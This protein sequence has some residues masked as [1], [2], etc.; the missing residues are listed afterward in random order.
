MCHLY[1]RADNLSRSKQFHNSNSKAKND[2]VRTNS[3]SPFQIG[4]AT[5]SNFKPSD[6]NN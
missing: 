5:T 2:L 6:A 4:R 3:H 1:I